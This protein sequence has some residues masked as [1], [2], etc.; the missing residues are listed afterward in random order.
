MKAGQTYEAF[1]CR[2]VVDRVY[3]VTEEYA[4]EHD[5]QYRVRY[6]AHVVAAPKGYQGF[7]K[8]DAALR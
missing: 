3:E 4:K 1:G 8:V 2:W 5:L 6:T 7:R